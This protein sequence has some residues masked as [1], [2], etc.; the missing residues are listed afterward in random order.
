MGLVFRIQFTV[1]HN[2]SLVYLL[3]IS[4]LKVCFVTPAE[5]LVKY[6]NVVFGPGVPG[7]TSKYMGP[8]TAERQNAWEELYLCE[9]STLH[10][11]PIS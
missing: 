9:Y 5:H 3:S 6:K 10:L 11:Y 4:V 7:K 8:P 1:C 2:L